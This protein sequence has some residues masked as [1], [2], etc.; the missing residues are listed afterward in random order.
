MNKVKKKL[1]KIN[2]SYYVCLPKQVVQI[3]GMG[4]NVKISIEGEKFIIEKDDD[5]G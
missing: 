1:I 5:N 4:I 3:I 2:E